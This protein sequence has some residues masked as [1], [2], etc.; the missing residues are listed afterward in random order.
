[1]F[2]SEA[3][4]IEPDILTVSK[5]LAHGLP[6]GAAVARAEVMDWEPGAHEGTLNGGPV[7]MEAAKAV[8]EVIAKENLLDRATEQGQYLKRQLLELQQR[9]PL[10]GDVRGM[11]LM[12]GIELIKDSRKTPAT[13][14][15]DCLLDGAFERGLLLLGAGESSVRLA[16]PLIITREQ[17]DI[18]LSIIEDCLKSINAGN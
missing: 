8:L 1:M 3:F 6:G 16:P 13:E 9:Y 17:I 15:R 10:I 12:V 11:G 5:S 7:I 18:G 14:E 4:G 2:A